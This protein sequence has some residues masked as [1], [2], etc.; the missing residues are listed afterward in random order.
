M[1]F[2]HVTIQDVISLPSSF[3]VGEHMKRCATETTYTHALCVSILSHSKQKK[4][5]I[6]NALLSYQRQTALH[7]PQAA[8]FEV[9]V[10]LHDG[11]TDFDTVA[12]IKLEGIFKDG[13]KSRYYNHSFMSDSAALI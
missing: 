7:G 10:D 11:T 8:V 9:D 13:P 3:D 6:I 12:E 2:L 5:W 4:E 1:S